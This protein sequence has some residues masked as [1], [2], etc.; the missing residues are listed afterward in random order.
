MKRDEHR[1]LRRLGGGCALLALL[2][3]GARAE[4]EAERILALLD[5]RPGATVADVGAGDGEWTLALADAVGA[6]GSVYATEVTEGLLESIRRRVAEAGVTNVRVVAGDQGATGL[7][8]A[9]CDGILLRLVYHHF[10]DPEAM[11]ADLGRALRSG[12]RVLVVETR[13]QSGWRKLEDVPERG[14][15]GIAPAALVAEMARS[16]LREVERRE[17]WNGDDDRYAVLF[18]RETGPSR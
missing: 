15:H 1:R 17:R 12:G 4:D 11:R 6:E 2:A 14:G 18:E 10:V 5:V 16:G 13:P 9:C 3:T 8:S 7:P